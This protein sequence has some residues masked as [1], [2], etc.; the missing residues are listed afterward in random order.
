MKLVVK[1]ENG[2]VIDTK[3]GSPSALKQK[4]EELRRYYKKAGCK[5]KV[6]LR[7]K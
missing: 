1:D 4:A 7:K 6:S 5:Y 2:I 3:Q